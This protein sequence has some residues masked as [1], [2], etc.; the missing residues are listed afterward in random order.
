MPVDFNKDMEKYI[1]AKKK[2]TILSNIKSNL[3]SGII[4]INGGR[5]ESNNIP[6]ADI[7]ALLE[8]KGIPTQPA[9]KVVQLPKE[10]KEAE[11]V[12]LKEKQDALN[13][14][15]K[16]KETLA[17]L[18]RVRKE[19]QM[20]TLRSRVSEILF[21]RKPGIMQRKADIIREIKKE[22][23]EENE[24][25]ISNYQKPETKSQPQPALSKPAVP[26]T[27]VPNSVIEPKEEK[28]DQI[29]TEPKPHE[30]AKEIKKEKKS[31]LS[32]FIEIKTAA[33][34]A[35][36]EEEKRKIEEQEAIQ[37]QTEINKLLQDA[38]GVKTNTPQEGEYI[39]ISEL[40]PDHVLKQQTSTQES[41]NN[42][43]SIELDRGYKI[44]VVKNN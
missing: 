21:K 17:E 14:K 5:K 22:K 16:E 44:R 6:Q 12:Q 19:Q 30:E 4:K 1:S 26:P 27:L 8:K 35:R 37:G 28:K 32:N 24:P 2:Q 13:E 41:T 33:E 10:N 11:N 7:T 38:E 42:G 39:D 34:I 3:L 43:E 25:D 31:F 9:E 29:Q 20:A 40:F 23:L 18:R 36:E 15:Q